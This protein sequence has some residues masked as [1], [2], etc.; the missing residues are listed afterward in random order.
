MVTIVT[1]EKFAGD[2]GISLIER[3][4]KT[5]LPYSVINICQGPLTIA[6]TQ[7]TSIGGFSIR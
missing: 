6:V 4:A 7:K 3:K 5:L 2:A 1:S